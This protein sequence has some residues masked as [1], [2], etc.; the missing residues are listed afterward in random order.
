MSEIEKIIFEGM[1]KDSIELTKNQEKAYSYMVNR[2][3]IFITGP[4][5]VG[6]TAVIKSFMR[7]YGTSREIAVT[8]T[9]G[10]SALLINGT[11]IHSYLGIGYGNQSIEYLVKKICSWNW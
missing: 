4:A 5:G 11:T 6:K 1:M 7:N 3:N 2:K 8:S 9:T 10:T